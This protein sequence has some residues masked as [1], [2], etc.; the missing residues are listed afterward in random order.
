MTRW[1]RAYHE[2]IWDLLAGKVDG[3]RRDVDRIRNQNRIRVRLCQ[4]EAKY[5][6]SKAEASREVAADCRLRRPSARLALCCCLPDPTFST[7]G[8]PRT[9]FLKISRRFWKTLLWNFRGTGKEG[10]PTHFLCTERVTSPCDDFLEWQRNSLD[11]GALLVAKWRNTYGFSA[12]S[13]QHAWRSCRAGS[14]V[15]FDNPQGFVTRSVW[16]RVKVKGGEK[17]TVRPKVHFYCFS[18]EDR[19]FLSR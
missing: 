11:M 16:V 15:F 3:R 8:F 1:N 4:E 13:R 5:R 9:Q 17:T 10:W 2:I 7:Y 19:L 6:Y 18:H 14:I 12:H